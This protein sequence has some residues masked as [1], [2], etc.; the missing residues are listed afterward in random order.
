M[1]SLV[2]QLIKLYHIWI[3]RVMAAQQQR[4]DTWLKNHGHRWD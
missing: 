3:Q 1:T 2:S 4:A